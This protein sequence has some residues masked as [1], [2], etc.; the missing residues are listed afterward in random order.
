MV[1]FIYIYIQLIDTNHVKLQSSYYM[2]FIRHL[3]LQNIISVQNYFLK[4]KKI[5]S[6]GKK[7]DKVYALSE[8]KTIVTIC[9]VLRTPRF[10]HFNNN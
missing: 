2:L 1:L 10:P 5:K 6:K 7:G 8:G 9:Y 3:I 4:V